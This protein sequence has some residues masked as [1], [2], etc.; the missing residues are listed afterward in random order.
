MN[1]QKPIPANAKA[2]RPTLKKV[3]RRGYRWL[4]VITGLS[5]IAVVSATAGAFLAMTMAST[6]LMQRKLSAAEA[7]V[8]S[9]GDLSAGNMHLPGLTR[10]VNIL[11]LGAKVLTSDVS[12][13]RAGQP[14][15][16]YH[17]LVNSFDGLTDTMLLLR[18]NPETKK[19]VLLSIPRDTR[20]EIPGHGANKINAANSLGGPAMSAQTVS[21]LMGGIGIDRYVTINVQ[22]VEALIDALGGVTVYVPK[23]M[24]YQDDSQH[25]YVNLKAG[26][27]HLNGNQALQLLRFRNDELGD[28]GRVQRQQMVM[29]AL[30]EQAL[31][32]ATL[33]RLPKILSVIKSHID[34]NLTVEE[35]VALVGFAT[36]IDRSNMQMLIVPGEYGDISTYGTSYWLPHLDRIQALSAQ[37]FNLGSAA[38]N[39]LNP[40]N[41]RVS[42]QDT[43]RRATPTAIVTRLE[44]AGF[45]NSIV[46]DPLGEPL[47]TTRIVAQQGDVQSAERV[48]SLLGVGEV[49]VESTGDLESDVTIQLGQDWLQQPR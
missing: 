13:E 2:S 45:T 12:D 9:Q 21:D 17:A 6:P 24:K 31:N 48:R 19:V 14:N 25:L 30:S 39:D 36:A 28:I 37:Y 43:T 23:D 18:F 22:G 46:V 7:A 42:V 1:P 27:Q 38:T 20:V 10:P 32:P 41:I 8:F 40:A 5:G 33:A 35:L 44:Q 16:G 29:R 11:V 47:T 15:L 34:T 26:K 4:W 49:R 3:S